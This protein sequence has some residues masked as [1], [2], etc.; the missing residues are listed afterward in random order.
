MKH[1]VKLSNG[2]SVPALGQGTWFIGDRAG[3]RKDEIEALRTGIEAGMTLI[4]TAEMYGSGRSE[5]LVG[6]AIAPYGREELFLVSKVLPGNAN[7]RNMEKALDASMKRMGVEYLDLYL[8]HWRGAT[9]LPETV[10]CLIKLKEKGKIREW[11][12]SNFDID[13]ME[14]LFGIDGGNGCLVNQD[15]YHAASRGIE[16]NLLPW[17]RERKVALMAYCPLAQAGSL[18]DGLFASKALEE[19]AKKHGCSLTQVLLAWDIRDGNT[20]A[21]PKAGR[22]E[23]SLLNA[24]ADEILLDEEDLAKIDEAFAPPARKMPLDVQ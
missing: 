8:Y 6:E 7:R 2:V 21:I 15:L 3:T 9:P 13:D 4:D 18:R 16:W 24:G 10:E 1:M 19:I 11:G 14:E 23:H 12:V 22:K 20:I 17:M 5:S